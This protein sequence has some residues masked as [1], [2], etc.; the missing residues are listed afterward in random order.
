MTDFTI[1]VYCASSEDIDQIYKD[2]AYNLGRHIAAQ[3]WNLVNGAGSEGLMAATS[4][5]ALSAGGKV[6]GIIPTFMIEAG[7]CHQ[8]LTKVVETPQMH[9][10]KQMMAEIADACIA[11]PGG[12]GTFEE[13]M[14]I[15]TWKTLG[16]YS[17]PIVVLNTKGYYQPLLDM[18]QKAV[19]EGFMKPHYLDAWSVAATAE[20]AIE[21]LKEQ[22]K[23]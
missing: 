15:I 6:T 17:K 22:L 1:C 12:C 14:E 11:L 18:L 5:G 20:E 10:R 2:E 3:G 19:D 7:W 8:G 23:H 13:L 9:E 16:I 4:N 21:Q